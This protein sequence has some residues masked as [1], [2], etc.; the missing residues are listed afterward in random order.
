MLLVTGNLNLMEYLNS[1]FLGLTRRILTPLPFYV[2]D[3]SAKTEHQS[4]FSLRCTPWFMVFYASIGFPLPRLSYFSYYKRL[5]NV[6]LT[7]KSTMAWTLIAFLGWN[8]RLNSFSSMLHLTILSNIVIFCNTSFKGWSVKI[9]M[10]WIWKYY[11]S[12][13]KAM[14]STYASFSILL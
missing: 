9:T 6:H 1:S 7:T 14:S 12:F 5:E 13:L 8:S 4:S 11:L 3:P 2:E 10:W